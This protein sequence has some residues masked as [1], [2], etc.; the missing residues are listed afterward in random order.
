MTGV[1]GGGTAAVVANKAEGTETGTRGDGTGNDCVWAGAGAE[2]GVGAGLA[3]ACCLLRAAEGENG[4]S[5]GDG[6]GWAHTDTAC[7]WG[8]EL[9][10][11][12]GR[13][14]FGG[15]R[16]STTRPD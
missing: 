4:I 9:T 3:C 13:K 14:N 15:K 10:F 6:I 5:P 16:C 12:A 11:F 1:R 7:A 2:A 8:S